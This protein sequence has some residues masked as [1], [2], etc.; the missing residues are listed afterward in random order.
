MISLLSIL[1]VVIRILKFMDFQPRMGSI[2]RTLGAAAPD[3]MH[4]FIMFSVIY[5]GFALYGHL[6]FGRTLDQVNVT[7]VQVVSL[8]GSLSLSFCL[9]PS[10][11]PLPLWYFPPFLPH[12]FPIM[13]VPEPG[14][15]PSDLL[16]LHAGR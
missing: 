9:P 10:L 11:L 2:T 15:V 4:F 16:H 6:V 1:L 12:T 14:H 3:L 13:S 8:L 5:F 7:S